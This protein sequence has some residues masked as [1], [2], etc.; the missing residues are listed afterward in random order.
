VTR[1]TRY[2]P[3]PDDWPEDLPLRIVALADVHA[4]WPWMTPGRIARIVAQANGLEPDLIVLLGDYVEGIKTWARPV[5][6]EQWA[7]AL[8][9]LRAPLGVHAILGN[10]DWWEDDKAQRSLEGPIFAR[11]ALEAVGIGV[12]END[13]VRLDHAGGGFWL[14]GLA[15]QRPLRAGD[16]GARNVGPSLADV[17]GTLAQVADEAPVILMAHE[18]DVFPRVPARVALTLAGHTHNGQI[19]VFG[20]TR[21]TSS[22]YGDRYAHGHVREAGRDLIVSAGLGMSVLPLRL[23]TAPEIVVVELGKG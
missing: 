12:Y 5:P 18:P 13:A 15:D 19:R 9:R 23:G 10:H 2:R 11:T 17:A 20:W 6:A 16:R 1:V 7:G 4:C 3:E 21:W 8:A 14:A 22:A